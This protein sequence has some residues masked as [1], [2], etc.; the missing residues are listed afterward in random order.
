MVS[1]LMPV[2]RNRPG[3][4]RAIESVLAQS[5]RDFEFIIVDDGSVDGLFEVLRE[6]QQRDARITLI[7]NHVNS[8]LPAARVN[9]GVRAARG[10]YLAYMFEDDEWYPD[11]LQIML[12][13]LQASAEPCAVYGI[14]DVGVERMRLGDWEFNYALLKNSNKIANCA[15]MHPRSFF[16]TCGLYDPHILVRR[17]SDYDLWL[18]MGRFFA[19]KPC[20]KVV[21]KSSD[22]N[23]RMGDDW[24]NGFL[25]FEL[26]WIE[27]NRVDAL[28]PENI[29]LYGVNTTQFTADPLEK[30]NLIEKVILPFLVQHPDLIPTQEKRPYLAASDSGHRLLVTK[31]DYSTSVDQHIRNF[32]EVLDKS[33][34]SSFFL[35]DRKLQHGYPENFDTLVL[36]RTISGDSLS[37]MEAARRDHK[38]VVYLM[39]DNMLQFGRGYLADEYSFL[40]PDTPAY[41]TMVKEIAGSD[42]V[43]SYST[44]ISEDCAVFNPKVFQFRE[45]IREYLIAPAAALQGG[46]ASGRKLKFAVITGMARRKELQTLWAELQEFTRRHAQE[47]EFYLWGFDPAEFG[48]LHCPTYSRPFDY[49]YERYLTA[50][51]EEQFDY[52]VCPLFPDHPAKISK[53]P[54]KYLESTV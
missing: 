7:R 43:I 47:V 8:G 16:D 25:G 32:E 23:G 42:Y 3:T 38:A 45:N 30:N 17:L 10:E 21:G 52:V 29:G 48:E 13:T 12:D 15:V 44:K 14:V 51:R 37:K 54:I 33:L 18:R 40:K 24:G 26:R 41:R 2:S 50:I 4:L 6:F 20:R 31:S 53:S 28:K 5:W 36:Y 35:E 19:F 9:Q 1:V 11:A 22:R 49:S 39:D 27:S 46:K 34:V